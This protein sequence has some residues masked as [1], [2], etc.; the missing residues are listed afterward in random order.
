MVH[1]HRARRPEEPKARLTGANEGTT[2]HPGAQPVASSGAHSVAAHHPAGPQR[3]FSAVFGLRQPNRTPEFDGCEVRI[4]PS[5]KPGGPNL[6]D[7]KEMWIHH[8]GLGAAVVILLPCSL[9]TAPRGS[10]VTR[11]HVADGAG[12]AQ[13]S[14]QE[15]TDGL[16]R[17]AAHV[18]DTPCARRTSRESPPDSQSDSHTSA[19]RA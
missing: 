13:P 19:T 15:M 12:T 9:T 10:C 2:R 4:E 8:R 3:S 14:S 17:I 7:A 16:A 5:S 11:E 1:G 6:L 18:A